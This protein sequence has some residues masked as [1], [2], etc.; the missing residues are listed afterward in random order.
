M[1]ADPV[2]LV[3]G[4]GVLAPNGRL[5][6]P[7]DVRKALSWPVDIG[8][9][10]LTAELIS[11]GHVRLWFADFLSPRLAKARLMLTH[12]T[13]RSIDLFAAFADRYRTARYY[14]SDTRVH[15]TEAVAVYLRPTILEE[16]KLY[17]ESRG[18]HVD[19]MTLDLRNVR[20]ERLRSSLELPDDCGPPDE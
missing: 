16:L 12:Q 18:D 10:S 17:V 19:V 2:K 5:V 15:F 3:G 4:I 7:A 11:P 8:P 13:E 14:P 9:V 1:T 6:I 20:L